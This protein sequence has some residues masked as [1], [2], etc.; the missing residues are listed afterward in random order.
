MMDTIAT[1]HVG[2]AFTWSG[3]SKK[4]AKKES[5]HS[6]DALVGVLF[7]KCFLSLLCHKLVLNFCFLSGAVRTNEATSSAS[8]E[9]IEYYIKEWMRHC[10]E[11]VAQT[12]PV[13]D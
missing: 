8:D 5:F 3:K 11:K 13:E 12:A 6:L 1:E 2:A 4:G 10:P 9:D 7:S